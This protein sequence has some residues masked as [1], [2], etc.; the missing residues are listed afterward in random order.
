VKALK[1]SRGIEKVAGLADEIVQVNLIRMSSCPAGFKLKYGVEI[2]ADGPSDIFH[3]HPG[4]WC[5]HAFDVLF[6]IFFRN[7]HVIIVQV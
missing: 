1:Y 4:C 7:A 3:G 2:L 6:I 5:P